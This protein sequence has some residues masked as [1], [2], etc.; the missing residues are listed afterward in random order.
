MSKNDSLDF[1]PD[2]P[3]TG[4]CLWVEVT[5]ESGGAEWIHFMGLSHNAFVEMSKTA[6]KPPWQSDSQPTDGNISF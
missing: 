3:G 4:P 6:K 1:D 2:Q 5:D